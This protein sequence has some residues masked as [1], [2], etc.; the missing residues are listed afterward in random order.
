MPISKDP[1]E[2]EA[3]ISFRN[4][5]LRKI[6]STQ[7]REIELYKKGQTALDRF[8]KRDRM[9]KCYGSEKDF[10]PLPNDCRL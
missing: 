9:E 10:F 3:A 7:G 1:Y 2:D 4:N 5:F 8:L 6:Q